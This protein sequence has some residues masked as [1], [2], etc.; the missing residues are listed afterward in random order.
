MKTLLRCGCL[1]CV[2]C[3]L[4]ACADRQ[5][6][7]PVIALSLDG[8]SLAV[9]ASYAG[10]TLEGSMDRTVMTGKGELV[11]TAT[12]GADFSCTASVDSMPTQKARVRGFL[13]CTGDRRLPFSLRNTGPDQGVGIARESAEGDLL[14][15]FYHPSQ[16]EAVRRLPEVQA[17]LAKAQEMGR[18]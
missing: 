5:A 8:P 18:P 14:V 1:I 2:S 3:L 4:C 13:L 7:P 16:E 10:M 11:L 6:P 15:M 17:D 9:A 12:N